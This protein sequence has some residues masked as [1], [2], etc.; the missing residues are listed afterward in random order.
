MMAVKSRE[1][2]RHYKNS[3][4]SRW[5]GCGAIFGPAFDI[6]YLYFVRQAA[7]QRL[8]QVFRLSY[9]DTTTHGA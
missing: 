7:L 3:G 6:Y 2:S 9:H 1:S 4:D 8:A 5:F